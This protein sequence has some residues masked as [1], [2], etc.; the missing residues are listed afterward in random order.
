MS[1][2]FQSV[3]T[4]LGIFSPRSWQHWP[5]HQPG[6][7][8]HRLGVRYFVRWRLPLSSATIFASGASCYYWRL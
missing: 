6:T 3:N 4:G 2:S 7:G 8:G 5:D 1:K